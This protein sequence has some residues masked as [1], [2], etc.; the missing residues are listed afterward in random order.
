MN[1]IGRLKRA[2]KMAEVTGAHRP[3][4]EYETHL[5][6]NARKKLQNRKRDRIQKKTRKRNRGRG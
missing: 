3:L 2:L 1:I 6:N 5:T 4:S